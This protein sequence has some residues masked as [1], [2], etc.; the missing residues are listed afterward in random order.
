[1]TLDIINTGKFDSFMPIW[2]S[3]VFSV[4]VLA[5]A[6]YVFQKRDF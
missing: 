5:A 4:V 2:T 3:A 6:Q 1:M